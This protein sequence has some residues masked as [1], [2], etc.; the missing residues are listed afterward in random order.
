[1]I[2]PRRRKHVSARS[3]F[4]RQQIAGIQFVLADLRKFP[5]DKWDAIIANQFVG[6]PFHGIRAVVP[7]K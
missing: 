3:T 5:I 7:G 1:M 2:A 6:G 4:P